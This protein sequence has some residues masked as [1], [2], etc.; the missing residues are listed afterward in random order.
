ML[1]GS[2][3]HASEPSDSTE[4]PNKVGRTI[5]LLGWMINLSTNRVMVSQ[6]IESVMCSFVCGFV[7]TT[8]YA[9]S[10]VP[11]FVGGAIFRSLLRI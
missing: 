4:D 5:D 3:V 8:Q 7:K 10:S 6:K 11:M 2:D 9:M 1:F